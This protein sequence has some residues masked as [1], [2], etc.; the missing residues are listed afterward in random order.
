MMLNKTENSN[1]QFTA[2]VS[3]ASRQLAAAAEDIKKRDYELSR[4]P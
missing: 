1:A 3:E 2:A 4:S